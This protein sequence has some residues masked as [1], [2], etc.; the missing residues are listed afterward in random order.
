MNR[1]HQFICRLFGHRYGAWRPIYRADPD[2]VM[3]ACRC[4]GKR[5]MVAYVVPPLAD[6]P[7]ESVT[8]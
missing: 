2:H 1:I 7:Q 6:Y 4:C 3:R 8:L 5:Q